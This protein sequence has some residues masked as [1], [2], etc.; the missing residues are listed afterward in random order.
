M[1]ISE[2]VQDLFDSFRDTPEPLDIETA[3]ADLD[4]F[5]SD[6]WP[7][8]DDITPEAYAEEWNR[9][10]HDYVISKTL[11]FETAR[12]SRC[13]SSFLHNISPFLSQFSYQKQSLKKGCPLKF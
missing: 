3:A 13:R 8:P 4:N 9:L 6:G 10:V 12:R 5:R 11:V 1:T 2:F 7:L